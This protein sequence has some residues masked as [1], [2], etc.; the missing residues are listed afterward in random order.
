MYN[1]EK[2]LRN[3][4]EIMNRN[5]KR[6][7]L[8]SDFMEAND[9]SGGDKFELARNMFLIGVAIGYRIRKTE[10]TGRGQGDK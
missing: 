3:G 8:L 2:Q 4:T 10:T 5:E 1:L 6:D 7:L 9:L